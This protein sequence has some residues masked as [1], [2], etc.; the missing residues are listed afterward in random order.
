M[1]IKKASLL[2]TAAFSLSSGALTDSLSRPVAAEVIAK[3][4]N[5]CYSIGKYKFTSEDLDTDDNLKSTS[6]FEQPWYTG[7]GD[8]EFASQ[9]SEQVYS[10]GFL[11]YEFVYSA[12]WMQPKY[13]NFE[14]YVNGEYQ[15]GFQLAGFSYAENLGVVECP[16]SETVKRNIIP[17]EDN[18]LSKVGATI[19]PIFEGGTLL[20]DEGGKTEINFEV[21]A[22]NGTI[23]NN[24]L[25]IEFSGDFSG[26][27][28]LDFN[29]KGRTILSGTNTYKGRTNIKNA[30]LILATTSSI[31]ATS[32][33]VVRR[34]GELDLLT[35]SIDGKIPEGDEFKINN[36]ELNPGGALYVSS[37][38]PLISESISMNTQVAEEQSFTNGGIA[39][40]LT[41]KDEEETC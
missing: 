33:T 3:L 15:G 21:T 17:G 36:L 7:T 41:A 25:T 13:F 32:R 31:D 19:D 26:K 39:V 2:F 37:R 27:G 6:I 23:N 12:S 29:G 38:N 30:T 22:E 20:V 4:E 9:L 14:A 18:L 34:E 8:G 40:S 10:K 35:Y 24:N 11:N 16:P 5:T 1:Q 28:G